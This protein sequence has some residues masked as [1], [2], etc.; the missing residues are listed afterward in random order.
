MAA[1]LRNLAGVRFL[2]LVSHLI[3]LIT[4]L[5]DMEETIHASLP[6]RHT[7]DEKLSI[8]THL[9]AVF[10]AGVAMAAVELTGLLLGIS[11]LAPMTALCSVLCHSVAVLCLLQSL[12]DAW[13]LSLHVCLLLCCS[14]LLSQAPLKM[15][16]T[17]EFQ[18]TW[19][20]SP[21]LFWIMCEFFILLT[22]LYFNYSGPPTPSSS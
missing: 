19:L 6:L 18:I 8:Q 17:T 13:P 2:C 3:L 15:V 4:L 10:S 20:T 14:F 5:V 22:T 9:T 1:S 16:T 7:L 21:F 12:L 11:I